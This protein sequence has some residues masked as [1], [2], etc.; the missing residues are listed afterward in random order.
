MAK[1]DNCNISKPAAEPDN[2]SA[3][4]VLQPGS[5]APAGKLAALAGAVMQSLKANKARSMLTSV[6]IVVG[7]GAVFTIFN[8]GEAGKRHLREHLLSYYPATVIVRPESKESSANQTDNG[9]PGGA[10]AGLM[11]SE[12][13]PIDAAN[14]ITAAFKGRGKATVV[15]RISVYKAICEGRPVQINDAVAAGE[16][17]IKIKKLD[18][19]SGRFFGP[20]ERRE[21][22]AVVTVDANGR[23]PGFPLK[24]LGRQLSLNGVMFR[25]IGTVR[26]KENNYGE[27]NVYIPL[28]VVLPGIQ[29]IDEIL[30]RGVD[31]AATLSSVKAFIDKLP[32]ATGMNVID[33]ETEAADSIK[34]LK[35]FTGIM[36]LIAAL[37]LLAGSLGVANTMLASVKEKTFES[38]LRSA[39]GASPLWIFAYFLFESAGLCF[40]AL[41]VGLCLGAAC[42]IILCGS[43]DLNTVWSVYPVIISSVS[44]MGVAVAGGTI[45][46]ILA[47]TKQPWEALKGI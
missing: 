3:K 35:T 26:I 1:T 8:L 45:P 23:M 32:N 12:A 33:A 21:A 28:G 31:A 42:T 47:A 19:G 6:S 46:S 16:D 15:K 10:L 5:K 36:A 4:K 25:I 38:G 41:A 2:L 29:S 40:F 27:N 13:I 37:S 14:S 11:S 30:V 43:M 20:L 34:L 7:V 24:P 22:V 44:A 18:M 39:F 9:F 17:I